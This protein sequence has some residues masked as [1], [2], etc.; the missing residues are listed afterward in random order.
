MTENEDGS[1]YAARLNATRG[2]G[3]SEQWFSHETSATEVP[4][5]HS[6]IRPGASEIL[7]KIRRPAGS[8]ARMAGFSDDSNEANISICR[9]LRSAEAKA[10]A[11]K[12]VQ[13]TDNWSDFEGNL[14]AG[15]VKQPHR[16]GASIEAKK[17]MEAQTRKCDWFTHGEKTVDTRLK[18]SRPATAQA[19]SSNFDW[20]SHDS[21]NQSI[22]NIRH[23]YRRVRGDGM[24]YAL[25]NQGHKDLL[26]TALPEDSVLPLYRC[27]TKESQN[28]CRHNKESSS[29]AECMKDLTFSE[30]SKPEGKSEKIRSAAFTNWDSNANIPT[31]THTNSIF[32]K[33]AEDAASI[34][35]QP[36]EVSKTQMARCIAQM[37]K[38]APP[39]PH[40]HVLHV[41]EEA[42]STY[43]K[44]RNGQMADL[45]GNGANS[46][47][48]NYPPKIQ[49]KSVNSEEAMSNQE[50][51]RGSVVRTLL[52]HTDLR[53][54][55]PR[56]LSPTGDQMK[57]ALGGESA[58][59]LAPPPR[60]LTSAEARSYADRQRGT[61]RDL[62]AYG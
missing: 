34:Q 48:Y 28:Y 56:R 46:T 62:L 13:S 3:D 21:T 45:I 17:I 31:N 35:A 51:A 54:I 16:F 26:T 41:S 58:Q 55:P 5:S 49:L 50:K 10:I 47:T 20:F 22:A 32:T 27:P 39:T 23:S 42:K 29:V 43:H 24:E 33:E 8:M 9:R 14:V 6:R 1:K 2:K 60:R 37:D 53:E 19:R 57:I 4:K 36:K 44:N 15:L 25:R 61:V 7:A 18:F 12:M 11:Q 52:T 30:K 40:R 59:P 38:D